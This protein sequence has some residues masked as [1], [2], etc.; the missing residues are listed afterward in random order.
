M[1][2]FQ[3]GQARLAT[4]SSA[5]LGWVLQWKQRESADYRAWRNQFLGD[6]LRFGLWITIACFFTFIVQGYYGLFFKLETIKADFI[7]AFGSADLFESMV[8]VSTTADM[9]RAV[10]LLGCLLLVRT[11]WGRRHSSLMFLYFSWTITLVPQMVGTVMGLPNPVVNDWILVFFA[12]A[13]L[14]PVHWGLHLFSQLVPLFYYVLVNVSLGTTMIGEHSIFDEYASIFIFWACAIADVSVFTYER[15]KRSEFESRRELKLFLHAVT[16]D[17]RAPVTGTSIV[18]Q[19]LLKNPAEKIAVDRADLEWLLRG[20]DRQHALINSLL[21]AHASELDSMRLNLEPISLS[22]FMRAVLSE[23][24]PS[25]DHNRIKVINLIRADLPEVMG[26]RH[27]LW[28][29]FCNL[30]TNALKH[31]PN[32]IELTIE[33]ALTT[34]KLTQPN[35]LMRFFQTKFQAKAKR[36]PQS[37]VPTQWICCSIRDNGIGIER[38][39]Q[40][41]LFE[42][43]TRG[44]QARYMPGL[45]LGLYLCQQIVVAHGG[46]MGVTS[47][48]GGGATFWLTLPAVSD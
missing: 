6:R 25:L 14:I 2:A 3:K 35:P 44:T 46:E 10:M 39:Q 16:H 40:K 7:D 31:N 26:D 48:L 45:G 24:Q 18:L 5:A 38:K 30:I 20:C 15:L 37:A 11:G 47:Q 32:G 19:S 42:L 8:R 23:L 12:Q 33:A 13:I 34:Q 43:Y 29:V 28:R 4:L 41:R 27:Q 1:N 22:E 21:E 17:L 9:I 36:N